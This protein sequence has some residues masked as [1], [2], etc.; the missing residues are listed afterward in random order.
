MRCPPLLHRADALVRAL[1]ALA[2]AGRGELAVSLRS[3]PTTHQ[4]GAVCGSLAADRRANV[5]AAIRTAIRAVSAFALV[6]DEPPDPPPPS[7]VVAVE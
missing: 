6:A 2:A 1:D 5:V 3:Q 4:A 7:L